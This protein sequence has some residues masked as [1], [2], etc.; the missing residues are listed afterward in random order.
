MNGECQ[1]TYQKDYY[2]KKHKY[3][4]IGDTNY[5]NNLVEKLIS[6]GGIKKSHKI[7][8][9]GCGRGRFSIP[10]LKRGYSLTCIDLSENLLNK[11]KKNI[12]PGMKVKIMK[13]DI[14]EMTK[15]LRNK[16]DFIIGFYILHHLSDLKTSFENMKIMLKKD[17]KIIFSENNPYNP[18]YYI[19]MIVVKD[20]NW[21]GE[22]GIL[23]IRK[24]I[25]Y[26]LLKS[27]KFKNIKIERYGFFPPH[28]VNT[29]IGQT[30][31]SKLE[32]IR[33]FYPLLPFQIIKASK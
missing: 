22:K 26:P 6:S 21:E 31:E 15:K 3:M 10:L 9:I 1:V 25:I 16:F 17:G 4:D 18:M 8:E 24:K 13:G 33:F 12:S 30:L 11:F 7:L 27:L 28:I 2:K 5:I 14:N 23:N 32:K 19:Q 20:I 29:R